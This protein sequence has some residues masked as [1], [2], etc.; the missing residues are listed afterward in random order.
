[1]Y[2]KGIIRHRKVKVKQCW[3][4]QFSTHLN[5]NFENCFHTVYARGEERVYYSI[6]SYSKEVFTACDA[7]GEFCYWMV[8]C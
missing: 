1:M 5:E 6:L 8:E 2:I 7:L 3:L 4:K